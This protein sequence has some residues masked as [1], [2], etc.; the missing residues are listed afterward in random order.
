[1]EIIEE[2]DKRVCCP[3]SL[4]LLNILYE[5]CTTVVIYFN[6]KIIKCLQFTQMIKTTRLDLESE[7]STIRI[8]D[9]NPQ[10]PVVRMANLCVVASHAV[11]GALI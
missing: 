9:N 5:G 2:I 11:S 8:L 4:F 10:K 6:V 7:L 1:M 3:P